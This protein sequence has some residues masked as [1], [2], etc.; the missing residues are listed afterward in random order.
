MTMTFD[1]LLA[2]PQFSL[3]QQQKETAL[4]PVLNELTAHHRAHCA[5]YARLLNVIY[6]AG[7]E[8][9]ARIA[10]V[11]FIP[12]GLFKTH[13]LQS[14]PKEEVFKTMTSSGTTG[15]QVSQIVIDRETARRQTTAL[16]RIM[17]HVLGPDRLPMV[18]IESGELIKDRLRFNARA[19]GVLGM[20]NFGRQHFYALD[21]EMKL[22]IEGLRVHGL[23]VSIGAD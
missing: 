6:P 10:D 18:L 9:A 20:A 1:D 2:R 4:T 5:D 19:A 17:M 13:R 8:K 23:A 15:Q 12:V 22:D 7:A 11:P 14:V 16:S 3:T 21:D